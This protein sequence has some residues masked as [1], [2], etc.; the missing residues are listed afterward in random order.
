MRDHLQDAADSLA[1][2]LAPTP[3]TAAGKRSLTARLPPTAAGIAR[4]LAAE[5]GAEAGPRGGRGLPTEVRAAFE[6]SLGTDLGEVRLHEDPDAARA[7]HALDAQA[8]AF[9]QDIFVERPLDPA[10]AGDRELLAHEVAHTVQ[11][12][13]APAPDG[14]VEVSSPG[15]AHEAEADDAA[16]A[17]LRGDDARV[18]RHG[19]VARKVMRWTTVRRSRPAPGPHLGPR[20]PRDLGGHRSLTSALG[21]GRR[22][23]RAR[24]PHRAVTA[25]RDHYSPQANGT[26]AVALPRL[27]LP[28]RVAVTVTSSQPTPVTRSGRVIDGVCSSK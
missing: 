26:V 18:S 17:M 13:G 6:A 27:P 5:R 19:G 25:G 22:R 4:A 9:D 10:D 24:L 7:A 11:Q 1:T 14:P 2:N 21:A 3:S 8:F 23:R 15:D 12:R 20:Q 28:D 16:A